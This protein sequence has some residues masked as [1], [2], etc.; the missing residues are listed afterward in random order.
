[1]R[2][3]CEL[4]LAALLIWLG[5]EKSFYSWTNQWRGVPETPS[6]VATGQTQS[7]TGAT[8]SVPHQAYRPQVAASPPSGQWMWDPAH[9]GTL[10][11]PAHDSKDSTQDYHDAAARKYWI[12]GQ[13]VK[14]YDSSTPP[15]GP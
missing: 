3:L 13:G 6:A 12:D 5:W 7:T 14:H 15:P 1:V 8:T 11:R 9:R 4:F 10:D 2:L